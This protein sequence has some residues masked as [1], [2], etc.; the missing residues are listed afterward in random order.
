[1]QHTY[2]EKKNICKLLSLLLPSNCDPLALQRAAVILCPLPPT[3]KT[4][5]MPNPSIAPDLLQPLNCKSIKPFLQIE[6]NPRDQN[7]QHD[8]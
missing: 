2:P 3:W 6:F 1:M 5:L 8:S 4:H 7:E